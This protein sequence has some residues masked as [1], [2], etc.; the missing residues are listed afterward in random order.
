MTTNSKKLSVLVVDAWPDSKGGYTGYFII[1]SDDENIKE[2]MEWSQRPTMDKYDEF[3][4][5]NDNGVTTY[6]ARDLWIKGWKH[7][8]EDTKFTFMCNEFV[9]I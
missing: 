3:V 9:A 5:V 1:P 8:S 7:T 2:L 4:F 6:K